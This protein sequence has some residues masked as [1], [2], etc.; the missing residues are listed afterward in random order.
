MLQQ[1][2]AINVIRAA[3]RQNLRKLLARLPFLH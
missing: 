2:D 1:G 3:I